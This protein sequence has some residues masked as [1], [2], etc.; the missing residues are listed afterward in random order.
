MLH[1]ALLLAVLAG[2]PVAPDS[3]AHRSTVRWLP[4]TYA[5]MSFLYQ[6][7]TAVPD[8][9]EFAACLRAR[10][11]GN[12]WVVT[13]VVIP[14]QSGNS[15][16]GIESADCA[17]YEGA[18]HSHPLF[19]SRRACFPSFGDRATFAASSN[20]FLVVWCDLE[21]FTYRTKD[22]GIGGKDDTRPDPGLSSS[23]EPY[24]WRAASPV[25]E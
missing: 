5:T 19:E 2:S 14:R 23:A 22:L 8:G 25:T 12:A 16:T 15:S 9:V 4:G 3:V 18:A 20:Q 11:E 24:L 21:A 6:R 10:R 13:E 17:G 1:T 7:I